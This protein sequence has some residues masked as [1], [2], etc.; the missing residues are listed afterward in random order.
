MYS[1]NS[2]SLSERRWNTYVGV[3]VQIPIGDLSARQ[4]EVHAKIDV[5]N[6]TLLVKNA[7]QQL[8]LDV[9]NSVRDLA[10]RWRQYEIAVR[11]RLREPQS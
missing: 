3:Q 6:Q 7:E 2:S 5:D 1:A 10:S 11:A 8:E 9:N 4:A